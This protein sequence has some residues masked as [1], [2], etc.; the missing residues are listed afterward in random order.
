MSKG[1]DQIRRGH[2]PYL[3]LDLEKEVKRVG[4][5][6]RQGNAPHFSKLREDFPPGGPPR[7]LPPGILHPPSSPRPSPDRRLWKPGNARARERRAAMLWLLESSFLWVSSQPFKNL[8][9]A[10]TPQGEKQAAPHLQQPVGEHYT[11]A[12]PREGSSRLGRGRF[13]T[14]RA[15]A[16]PCEVWAAWPRSV[17]W[18]GS[19][20]GLGFPGFL[21]ESD[22]RYQYI[23]FSDPPRTL[24]SPRQLG[25]ILRV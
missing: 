15:R 23:P 17:A 20:L 12:N 2:A 24:D 16:V 13:S 10:H 6:N 25:A 19:C 22:G 8:T 7:L 9:R 11:S 4:H 21:G 14:G 5:D 3:I 1:W 18:A